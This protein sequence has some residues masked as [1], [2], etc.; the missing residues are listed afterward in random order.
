MHYSFGDMRKPAIRLAGAGEP[1]R[2]MLSDEGWEIDL[3]GPEGLKCLV[4]NL[5]SGKYGETCF[6]IELNN[7]SESEIEAQLLPPFCKWMDDESGVMSLSTNYMYMHGNA[8]IMGGV[9][10]L[11]NHS[12]GAP[13]GKEQ[14]VTVPIDSGWL[15][16]VLIPV[17]GEAKLAPGATASYELHIDS[18]RGDRNDALSEIYRKRGAYLVDPATYDFS[19]YENPKVQWMKDIVAM[20]FNWA[21][22]TN[23]MDPVT[24][25]Y[26][27]AESLAEWKKVMGGYDAY[28]FWPFWPR[29]GFDERSQFDHFADMP[30]GIEGLRDEFRK[31]R[32]LGT[33]IVAAYCFWSEADNMTPEQWENG[34]AAKSFEDY[35]EVACKVEADGACLDCMST[36]PE[37]LLEM[38][39]AKGRE[40]L[41]Y[42]EGDPGWADSQINLIGRI[43]NSWKM[44]GFSLKRYMLPH[45]PVLR[46]CES[47]RGRGYFRQNFVLSFFNGHGVE[48]QLL[49]PDYTCANDKEIPMLARLV[50][51]LRTNRKHFTSPD[52][53]SF[54]ESLDPKVWINRWPS[55]DR[56]IYTLCGTDPGGHHGDLMRLPHNPDVHYVDLWNCKPIDARTEDGFDMLPYNIEGYT[57][58]LGCANAKGDYSP[59]CI[60]VFPKLINAEI[61]LEML[62]I[63][64]AGAA[65]GQ[66]LEIWNGA[67][68]PAS[69]PVRIPAAKSVE[70]NLYEKFGNTNKAIIIRLLAENNQLRDMFVLPEALYRFFRM[71][72]FTETEPV[73]SSNPPQGM[74]RIPGVKY[75]Y[76]VHL[77]H[78]I[79]QPTYLTKPGFHYYALTEPSDPREVDLKPFWM[80]RYPVTNAQFAE[81]VKATGYLQSPDASPILKQNFLKHFVNSEPP[82]GLEN[83]PVVYVSY[84]DAKAYAQWAGKRLPTEEEWQ[85]AAGAADSRKYPWGSEIE[86]DRCNP[87][88]EGTT[89]VNAHPTGA[90]PYGIEDMVGNI[91]QWT[92]GLYDVDRHIIA[93]V[94]GGCWF[95]RHHMS[96]WVYGGPRPINDH[97]PLPLCG[98]GLNRFSTVG[99]R[100]VKDE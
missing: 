65:D 87:G 43:H 95:D 21:W 70:I 16:A 71:E 40:L 68:D 41:P 15:S 52:W 49:W 66:V 94:R 25:E 39:S 54:V 67:I 31:M 29:A 3:K 35:V 46:A 93:F 72:K 91:W 5:P 79:W 92:H 76:Q 64:L 34:G 1:V 98:P 80:D 22:D 32:E 88:G 60:A 84:E 38:S 58:G 2:T 37:Q 97:H 30:G 13:F 77:T 48:I 89:P 83:H 6:S 19:R 44:P 26:R 62:K 23:N 86:P 45:H 57:P 96:W 33:R 10:R 90:S 85:F 50:D 56:V 27:L 24:G 36:T 9:G 74:V 11:V 28:L 69:E 51:I 59:G 99:F 18:G 53:T 78:A 73:D 20:W 12:A 17:Q 82:K 81:F 63:E 14:F 47:G 42:N 55:E 4:K 75:S 61:D 7:G 8:V 100:C